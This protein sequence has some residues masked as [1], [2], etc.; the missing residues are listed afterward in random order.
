MTTETGGTVPMT[1]CR[2]FLSQQTVFSGDFPCPAVRLSSAASDRVG[3]SFP[4]DFSMKM[5][6]LIA[7]GRKLGERFLQCV[8][9]GNKDAFST[10]FAESC[11]EACGQRECFLMRSG[12]KYL[13]HQ[14][15]A[16]FIELFQD[17][18]QYHTFPLKSPHCVCGNLCFS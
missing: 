4:L 3:S 12:S 11:D 13:V 17:L 7:E 10:L 14:K 15:E 8:E 6:H 18:G 2:L 1:Q 9:M 16:F 5:I